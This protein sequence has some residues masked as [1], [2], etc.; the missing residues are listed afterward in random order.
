MKGRKEHEGAMNHVGFTV[1]FVLSLQRFGGINICSLIVEE[2]NEKSLLFKI[3]CLITECWDN[4]VN[5]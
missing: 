4:I 1:F 2:V 5:E 3:P